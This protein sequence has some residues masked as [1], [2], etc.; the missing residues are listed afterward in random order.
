LP[1][2][3]VVCP[4]P[5]D[6]QQVAVE[7]LLCARSYFRHW[8]YSSDQDKVLTLVE[9]TFQWDKLINKLAN[10]DHYMISAVKKT[11]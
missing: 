9:L 7:W 4:E 3:G 6:I 1:Y 5:Y 11:E 10:K 8:G 2:S